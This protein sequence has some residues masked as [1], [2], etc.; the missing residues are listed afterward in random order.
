MLR[1]C[2]LAA[3]MALATGPQQQTPVF[4]SGVDL[5]ALDVTVVDKDGKPVEG[6][7]AADFV[8]TLNGKPGIVRQMD[9]L[10][11]G[12]APGSE[13]SVA[14]VSREA[15]NT[16]PAAAKASRGG[17][18][19][20][21]LIDDLA[22]KAGEGKGLM[23]AAERMLATLDLGDMV[24][25]ATT[26]GLGPVVS[27]TRD[28][29][30][31][32]ATLKSRGVVGR[33]ENI[34]LPFFITVDEALAF[35]RGLDKELIK[36]VTSRE[37]GILPIG[38]GCPEL[39]M[40]SAR[41]LAQD[42]VHRSAMQ[43]RAYMEIMKAL[44]AAPSPRVLIALSKGVAPLAD[45]DY[46]VLDPVSH[47]AAD[48]GV[49][50]YALT[51]VESLTDVSIADDG[52]SHPMWSR[53]A[54]RRRENDFMT[55]GV[56]V[57]ATAAGGEAFRVIGQADRFFTRIMAETSGVYRLGVE[58]A[59]GVAG[60]RYL[61]AK[62][63]VRR[64]GVMVRAHR[65]ALA[66][67]ANAAPVDV[68]AALRARV[69]SGGVAFGVPIALATSLRRDPAAGA[70]LQ[71]GVN[72]Q[73]PANVAAPLVTMFALVDQTG[74]IVNAGRQPV[75]ASAGE[76]YQLAFPIGVAPGTYRLRFAVADAAGNIGSVEQSVDARLP[77]V[78]SVTVS[79]LVVTWRDVDDKNRFLALETVPAAATSVRAFLE[80]YR[81]GGT[82]RL[83]VRFAVLKAGETA[84]VLEETRTP[85]PDG[86]AL[87]AGIDIPVATLEA[88][89]YTLR[90]TVVEAGVGTGTV[91]T[92]FRKQ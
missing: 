53:S 50:F 44:K 85:M 24:G 59:S 3:A 73:M 52:G 41:R 78:G 79:D 57:V 31:V 18:V 4:K 19:V 12:G 64:S 7:K 11:Y 10:S 89:S 63:S 22:A 1:S 26:S 54:A 67:A 51:E 92:S 72:I 43:L 83:E 81:E 45:G 17:R 13:V 84:P 61:D 27:P 55:S 25:L 2:V 14:A 6:L 62:V 91:T 56:Q 34:T 16:A 36:Q 87:S 66:A 76:D 75:P 8:V 21:I 20:V 23:V 77:R 74:K 5:V 42:T 88:G 9:Y 40:V 38:E 29:D 47:A 68:D 28:R 37:C 86:N 33:N 49:Q 69:A 80:L 46:R 39:V 15:S 70:G 48:A 32:M 35:E 71:L 90:A 58:A 30:A 82:P 65:H 60:S